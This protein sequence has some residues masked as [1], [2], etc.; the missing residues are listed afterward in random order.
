VFLQLLINGLAS[1]CVLAIM[2]LGFALIYNTTHVFHIAHG[3][4]YTASAYLFFFF[5]VQLDWNFEAAIAMTLLLAALIGFL[6]ELFMYAPLERRK[7]SLLVSFLSS[8]GFYIA[9]INLIAML[10]GNETKLLPTAD[11]TTYRLNPIILTEIQL[12][13]IIIGFILLPLILILL[14]SSHLG[15]MILAVR[16]NPTLAMVMG[17]NTGLVRLVVFAL[18]S[19]LAGIAALLSTLDIGTSPHV[20]MP[21]L[22][23][24]AVA[25]IVGGIGTFAGAALG[26]VLIGLLQSM[27][28]WQFSARWT[29]TVTYLA[30]ILFLLFRPQGLL[31]LHRRLE[32]ETG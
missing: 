7:A 27:V 20:G 1:G 21:A 11:A 18:G 30:L 2:A 23:A 17:V 22:L 15:R 4:V 3:A 26:G 8:L 28:I 5:V 25:L 29:D 31:G 19:M 6:L 12:I 9:V 10:F 32:E 16:D 24:A 13:Q 14:K